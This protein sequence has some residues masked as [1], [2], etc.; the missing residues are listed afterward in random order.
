MTRKTTRR[1]FL[2]TSV[3]VAGGIIGGTALKQNLTSASKEQPPVTTSPLPNAAPMPER[4][5][6]N[7][8]VR[9]PIFG[10]GGAGHKFK[11]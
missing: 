11:T 10:L 3:A 7:T 4:E 1:T 9:V 5:L 2:T 8:G 6:G